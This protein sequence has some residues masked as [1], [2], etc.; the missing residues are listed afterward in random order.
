[1]AGRR[2]TEPED[3]GPAT[4]SGEE[5]SQGETVLRRPWQRFVFIAGLGGVVFVLLL[6]LLGWNLSS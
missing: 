1:M 5:A 4:Y 3:R 6:L 2:G